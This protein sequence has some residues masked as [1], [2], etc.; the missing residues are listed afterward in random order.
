MD[1]KDVNS[2]FDD[3]E[4]KKVDDDV[5]KDDDDTWLDRRSFD[6]LEDQGRPDYEWSVASTDYSRVPHLKSVTEPRFLFSS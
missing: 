3:K 5:N 6:D 1:D 2:N 4:V